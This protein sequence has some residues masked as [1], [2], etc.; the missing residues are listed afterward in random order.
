MPPSVFFTYVLYNWISEFKISCTN[1]W[2]RNS[3][4]KLLLKTVL[5]DLTGDL[6]LRPSDPKSIGFQGRMCRPSLRK[7][8][9]GV[10]ELLIGN[11]WAHLTLVTLTF[12]P[13][14]S[15][16]IYFLY[17]PGWMCWPSLRRVGQGFATCAKL[18]P[19]SSSNTQYWKI[20]R[21]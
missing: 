13:V 19:L 3:F 15:K 16:W 14:T 11:G 5:A 20:C 8:G 10:L 18:Y 17:Y 21:K 6:D 4:S 1:V 12:D 7:V 2:R 9:Q